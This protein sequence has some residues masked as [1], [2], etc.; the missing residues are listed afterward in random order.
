MRT[1]LAHD[2]GRS[3]NVFFVPWE[4]GVTFRHMTTSFELGKIFMVLALPCAALHM[5]SLI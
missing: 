1:A 3:R 2:A 4:W 5:M